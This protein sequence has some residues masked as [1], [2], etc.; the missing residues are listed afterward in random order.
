MSVYFNL[1]IEKRRLAMSNNEISKSKQKRLDIENA[2]KEQQRKKALANLVAVLIPVTV[3]LLI[4]IVYFMYQ[5]RQLNYGK[6]LTEEGLISDINAADYIQFD[7]K[8]LSYNRAD[9]L[10][11]DETI[12]ADIESIC[13]S[14]AALSDDA[15]LSTV[16]ENTISLSYTASIGGV[17]YNAAAQEDYTIGSAAVSD[18]FDEALIGRHPGDSYQTE[19]T[20]PEDYYNTEFAGV[21]FTYDITIHGIYVAP[22][23]TDDLVSLHFPSIAT[24]AE[25]YREYLINQYYEENLRNAVTE[26][27]SDGGIV[28]DYPSNYLE[29]VEKIYLAQNLQQY[30]QYN[31]MFYESL[32]Y[33]AYNSVYE[34]YGFSTEEEYRASVDSMAANDVAYY[35]AVMTVFQNEGMTNTRDEVLAYYS[36]QGYDAAAFQEL[37]AQYHFNYLAQ[38]ALADKVTTYLMD[39]VTVIE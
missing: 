38:M 21:T 28:T 7:Y 15:A 26:S 32:G 10:P 36:E 2:R 17:S 11:D 12:E 23:F 16:S 24:T 29:N 35:L 30:N 27:L 9:L 34:M 25:G 4:C 22:E 6:Y 19:I 31:Q 5:S 14:L 13:E 37:E 20:Y 33:Y 1:N 18:L 39:T 3:I 8:S